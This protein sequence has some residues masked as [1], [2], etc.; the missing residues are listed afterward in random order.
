MG[1][2][3]PLWYKR[4]TETAN[5]LQN[6]FAFAFKLPVEEFRHN[7]IAEQLPII[8]CRQDNRAV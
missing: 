8:L 3:T 6:K 4:K 2:G 7:I 1:L 5:N